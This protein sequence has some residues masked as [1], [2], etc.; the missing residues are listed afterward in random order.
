MTEQ[1]IDVRCPRC[2]ETSS[3]RFC[4]GCGVPLRDV[5][6]DGCGHPAPP[7]SRFCA[8]CGSPI[9]SAASTGA[10]ESRLAAPRSAPLAKLIGGAALLVLVAFVAGE[11]AARRS[12]DGT[13]GAVD[14]P[15]TTPLMGAA[16]TPAPDISAMSPEERASRLFNRVMLYS[17]QGKMDSA[18][19]F[20]PMA[21]Q[22]YEMMGP[23]DDHVRYDI[24]AIS[25]A[26]GDAAR[27]RGEADTIL[28]AQPKHLL[29]LVLAIR[30]ADLS[31]DS[32]AVS[33]FSRR[34]VAAA[35][36]ERASTTK[37]YSEHTRDID[38]A[39]KKAEGVAR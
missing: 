16:T 2:G 37:G 39:I 33:R 3:G 27:A 35:P 32:A 24:G 14:Q 38:D 23:V 1:S 8:D 29:G 18:R 34:L 6:C 28:T 10:V 17:E 22:A 5:K 31:K 4:S 20:A 12:A 9:A 15:V 36:A 26:V 19:F 7:G 30:A 25:A 11:A 13:A 21:I